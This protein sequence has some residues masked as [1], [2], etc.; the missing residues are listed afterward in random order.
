MNPGYSE[1]K[2]SL[3]NPVSP[4]AGL[5]IF[6]EELEGEDL[7]FLDGLH[8]HALCEQGAETLASVLSAFEKDFASYIKKMKWVNFGGGHH[9]TRPGYNLE[10]L[11]NIINSFKKRY[12]V[13][14]HLEPGEAIAMNAGIL[15]SSVLDILPKTSRRRKEIAFLDTSAE[16][17]MPDVLAMPY[18][19][20]LL[21]RN[22]PGHSS[23]T[24]IFRGQTCLAGDIIGE[25]ALSEKLKPGDRVVFLDMAIYTMVKTT[26]FNGVNLPSIYLLRKSGLLEEVKGFGY[27]DYK[28]RL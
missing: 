2:V 12:G 25:Y 17:H 24:Y 8:F 4:S 7:S 3:Y 11:I 9:I 15:V 22:G 1:V 18:R 14:V 16:D 27:K 19:P 13:Q 10:Y 6:S 23:N 26:T 21:Q 20:E 28:G 5:G